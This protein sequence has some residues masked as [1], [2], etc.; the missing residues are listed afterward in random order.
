MCSNITTLSI[1]ATAIRAGT[2]E[3]RLPLAALV[4]L[5]PRAR[6]PLLQ[7]SGGTRVLCPI[8]IS[9]HRVCNAD[10]ALSQSSTPLHADGV[11]TGTSIPEGVYTHR[12]ISTLC[13]VNSEI[14]TWTSV[15]SLHPHSRSDP[16]CGARKSWMQEHH[17]SRP[18]A[19]CPR[20][21]V[22]SIE[23]IDSSS[24]QAPLG[25]HDRP[26]RIYHASAYRTLLTAAI[27]HPL[28]LDQ[29]STSNFPASLPLGLMAVGIINLHRDSP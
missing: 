3:H 19:V 8:G 6:R 16:L 7:L 5:R 21:V 15:P 27:L 1:S 26:Y 22:P 23:T 18:A 14:T 9:V 20:R 4:S 28:G 25:L 13:L 2:L 12:G 24:P 10:H 17:W 29:G 11:S